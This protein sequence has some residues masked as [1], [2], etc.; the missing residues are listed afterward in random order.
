MKYKYLDT[1]II[2]LLFGV[3]WQLSS[4]RFLLKSNEIESELKDDKHGIKMGKVF[5]GCDDAMND[6]DIDWDGSPLN[7][8]CYNPQ[9]PL[10]VLKHITSIETCDPIP[11][12][13]YP[14]HHCMGDPIVYNTTLPTYGDHRPLWPVFGEYIFVPKQRWLHNIEHGAVVMLYHPCANKVLV[15][16]LRAL[17]TSCMRKHVITA[18]NLMDSERPLALIAWGCR[19]TMNTVDTDT[20]V[21]FIKRK[22]MKGPEG[23]Y[24]KEGQ[25]KH[26]LVKLA[27]PPHGSDYNDSKICPHF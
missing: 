24:P 14:Q 16:R 4:G 7:Y 15:S 8:T 13:Y 18:Y 25:Y 1:T 17:V 26:L 23:P 2:S 9:H 27:E 19:L 22:S 20:V 10:P 11:D 6:L 21:S 3:C 12:G 5:H